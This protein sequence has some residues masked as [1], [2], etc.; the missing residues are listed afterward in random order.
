MKFRVGYFIAL[1]LLITTGVPLYLFYFKYNE[2]N[3]IVISLIFF[4]ALNSLICIWEISLGLNINLIKKD[5]EKLKGKYKQQRGVAVMNFFLDSLDFTTTFSLPYWSKV[6]SIYS[7][8]DP[9]YSNQESFGFFVDVGNG[10]TTLIPSILFIACI[11]DHT[12]LDPKVI[13][14]IGLIKFYQELYGTSIYFLSYIYNKRY[15]GSVLWIS[16]SFVTIANGIWFA[17]PLLGMY[18]CSQ[19]IMTDTY[20]IFHLK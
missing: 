9:S 8:F 11:V 10:W 5:Y 15:I 4:L 19:M 16:L 20:E 13:G 17:F 1:F 2:L 12:I 18:A 3:A 6:W 14:M 7:L